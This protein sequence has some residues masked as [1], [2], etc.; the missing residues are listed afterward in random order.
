[1]NKNYTTLKLKPSLTKWL[2][3]FC[4][5][6]VFA[7]VGIVMIKAGE[8]NGWIIFG[9]F[10][11]GLIIAP[12]HYFNTYLILDEKGYRI[13]VIRKFSGFNWN[14]VEEFGVLSMGISSMVKFRVTEGGKGEKVL[15]D[16]FGMK[17][18]ELAELMAEYKKRY[19]SESIQK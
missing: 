15:P 12:L 10:L 8:E 3:I 11:L 4:L 9:I 5:C 16:T 2:S 14:Q 17:A 13:K 6:A 18:Y 7:V 1:M 19:D